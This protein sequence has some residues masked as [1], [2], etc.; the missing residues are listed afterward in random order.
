M[1]DACEVLYAIY[2]SLADAC[3][4][5][6]LSNLVDKVFGLQVRLG[7]VA[8]FRPLSRAPF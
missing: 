8:K 4:E 2:E 5:A 3:E 7:C 6:G 1:N